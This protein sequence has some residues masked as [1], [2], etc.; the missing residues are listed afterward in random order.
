MCTYVLCVSDN[1]RAVVGVRSMVQKRITYTGRR[2]E[3]WRRHGTPDTV[4]AYVLS[5]YVV[6]VCVSV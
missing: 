4:R 3:K 1:A 2:K 6:S 5:S